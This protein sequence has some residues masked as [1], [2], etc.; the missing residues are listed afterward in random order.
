VN[1]EQREALEMLEA[2]MAAVQESF[3]EDEKVVTYEGKNMKITK[4]VQK[5]P[6]VNAPAGY[7]PWK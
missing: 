6:G 3:G 2:A 5:K 7:N 1:A 4:T